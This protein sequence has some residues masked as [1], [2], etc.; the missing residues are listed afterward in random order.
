M[1]ILV[2][3]LAACRR[4][5]R[6]AVAAVV[7]ASALCG[8][9]GARA[10][11]VSEPVSE[12]PGISVRDNGWMMVNDTVIFISPT[13]WVR[14]GGWIEW[15]GLIKAS[16]TQI[17]ANEFT[18]GSSYYLDHYYVDGRFRR[19]DAGVPDFFI[20][21]FFLAA[22]SGPVSFSAVGTTLRSERGA[23]PPT[24]LFGALNKSL[25]STSRYWGHEPYW[26]LCE[27]PY[28]TS[29]RSSSPLLR[30]RSLDIDSPLRLDAGDRECIAIKFQISPPDPRQP[31]SLEIDGLV[32]DGKSVPIR[33]KYRPHVAVDRHS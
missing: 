24:E 23:Y 1:S 30:A 19:E 13:N 16:E 7:L 25:A 4:R 5:V 33:I 26:D 14:S 29:A 28:F 17:P 21:E 6:T 32:I 11:L 2:Q 18:F 8:C 10:Y 22:G 12:S 20:L 3:A 27:S 31:F 9:A 15:L